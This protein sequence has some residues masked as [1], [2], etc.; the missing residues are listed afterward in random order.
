MPE[1][2]NPQGIQQAFA[3]ANAAV[4]DN[5]AWANRIRENWAKAQNDRQDQRQTQSAGRR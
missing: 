3:A 4:R 5:Q 1:S 2:P